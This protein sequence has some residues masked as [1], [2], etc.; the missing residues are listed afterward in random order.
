[1]KP[2][3]DQVLG[4]VVEY[5]GEEGYVKREHY[6]LDG[7]KIEANANQ[8]KGVWA[9]RTRKNQERLQGKI[10][11]LLPEIEETNAAEPAVYGEKD[12]EE[13][14]GKGGSAGSFPAE[15]VEQEIAELDEKLSA[16]PPIR[17]KPR[18]SGKRSPRE[19][20][21]ADPGTEVGGAGLHLG[22]AEQRCQDR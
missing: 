9:K 10:Q 6:F 22:G 13:N 18:S 8:H 21:T 20:R 7:T 14:G 3:I 17:R 19:N 12:R 2:V 16:S 11:Q 1:M 4:A 15:K 5:L